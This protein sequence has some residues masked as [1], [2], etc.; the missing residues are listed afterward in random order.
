MNCIGH[1]RNHTLESGYACYKT[2]MIVPNDWL[3]ILLLGLCCCY[4]VSSRAVPLVW[5]KTRVSPPQTGLPKLSLN[6]V[7]R[8][9]P[10]LVKFLQLGRTLGKL[11]R[12]AII[13]ILQSTAQRQECFAFEMRNFYC[14]RTG[15]VEK[16]R[17]CG[18]A[19]Y[20]AVYGQFEMLGANV[21]DRL[22]RCLQ[23]SFF[24]LNRKRYGWN[25][26]IDFMCHL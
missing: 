25:S 22:S 14:Y 4:D 10:N 12:Y 13:C 21:R 19:G 15:P 2:G 6:F 24:E 23:V 9:F 18:H 26:L 1:I 5:S 20:Y 11:L 8:A 7:L 16:N 17:P 3:R